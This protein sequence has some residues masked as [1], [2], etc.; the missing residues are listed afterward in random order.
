MSSRMKRQAYQVYVDGDV[1]VTVD[2]SGQ[3]ET[4]N[5]GPW[6]PENECSRS[7][8][9]GVQLEKRQCRLVR[10]SGEGQGE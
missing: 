2:K 5:W 9:G 7:C 1:S 8:G 4:G 10:E 3:K 6:V